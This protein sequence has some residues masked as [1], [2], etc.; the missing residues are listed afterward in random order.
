MEKASRINYNDFLVDFCFELGVWDKIIW[1]DETHS[2]NLCILFENRITKSMTT[3]IITGLSKTQYFHLFNTVWHK[4]SFKCDNVLVDS[5]EVKFQEI[6]KIL[7]PS[8]LEKNIKKFKTGFVVLLEQ[9]NDFLL[10]LDYNK[11]DGWFT[12]TS[13]VGTQMNDNWEWSDI[14]R[15]N[16]LTGLP[17]I[18][19]SINEIQARDLLETYQVFEKWNW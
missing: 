2:R 10:Y 4:Y 18:R 9:Q 3:W 13:I 14:K 12:E 6:L 19:F 17:G 16:F 11:T 5:V 15:S 1:F 8:P 7:N